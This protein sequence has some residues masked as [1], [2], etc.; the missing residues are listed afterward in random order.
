ML[1]NEIGS[2]WG[3][4]LHQEGKYAKHISWDEFERYFL[5]RYFPTAFKQTKS[6]ELF[7]L[8][9]GTMTVLEYVAKFTVLV[10]F[11]PTLMADKEMKSTR[12]RQGLRDNIR[13]HVTAQG[14][15][16]YQEMVNNAHVLEKDYL[17]SQKINPHPGRFEDRRRNNSKKISFGEK[18][19]EGSSNKGPTPKKNRTTTC[20]QEGMEDECSPWQEGRGQRRRNCS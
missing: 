7:T 3:T 17:L 6:Q 5:N 1:E 16:T 9:Q 20:N 19:D 8:E 4:I 15:Q 2:W 18:K 14:D 12:F 10:H 13:R 11:A